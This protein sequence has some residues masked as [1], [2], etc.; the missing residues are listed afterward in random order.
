MNSN[1]MNIP[2]RSLQTFLRRIAQTYNDI[3]L[4]VPDGIFGE[5]TH[6]AVVAFEKKFNMKANGGV[7]NN[8]LWDKIISVY[9][10]IVENQSPPLYANIFPL[11]A[12]VIKMNDKY[13]VIYIIQAMLF[14]LSDYFPN[15]SNIDMTGI[16]DDKTIAI[17]KDLQIIFGMN[18]S[19]EID[20]KFWNKLSLLYSMFITN[21]S[22]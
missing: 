15:L 13:P 6:N 12:G 9:D 22:Q 21:P 20:K 8:T 19:G 10:E 7:V 18:P 17:V 5:Q 11:N 14:N 3:P 1:D 4:V 2:V 16:H